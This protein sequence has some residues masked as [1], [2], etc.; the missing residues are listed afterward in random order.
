MNSNHLG[1]TCK[2]TGKT[3]KTGM[4][5]QDKSMTESKHHGKEEKDVTSIDTK[6]ESPSAFANPSDFTTSEEQKPVILLMAKTK[7]EFDIAEAKILN[8]INLKLPEGHILVSARETEN[9]SKFSVNPLAFN[10]SL[11]LQQL[12]A[13]SFGRVLLLSS[14]LPSTHSLL[15]EN[16]KCFPVGTLCVADVQNKGRGRG[17]NLWESPPG[18]LMFSITLQESN[19]RTLPFLQYVVCLALVKA[20][21]EVTSRRP[22]VRPL[23]VGIKWP[24]DLYAGGLKIGGILCTSTFTAD[25]KLFNVVVG[26]GL[27]VSNEKPTACLNE[28]LRANKKE[29]EEMESLSREEILAAVVQQLEDL[30]ESFVTNGFKDLQ[31]AYLQRWLH[32]GQ[33]VELEEDEG[34]TKVLLTVK[35]LTTDGYL[36]ALNEKGEKFELHPDGN[37]LDFFKGL[38]RRKIAANE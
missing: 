3:E 35:G 32:T 11:F 28:L 7:D 23:D 34:N 6:K 20:I 22:L 5:D 4:E 38:A 26:C 29:G 1:I 21:E 25:E 31:E 18:C 16:F 30:H 37:S 12:K 10:G 15:S 27:N 36:L 24:N 14:Q 2:S 17:G 33:K 9:V 13:R 19:G 8:S